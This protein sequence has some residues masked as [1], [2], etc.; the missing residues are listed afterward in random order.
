[1]GLD[2]DK[3][4][5]HTPL[6]E[7]SIEDASRYIDQQTN[8]I[9]Y[10]KTVTDEIVDVTGLSDSGFYI[11]SACINIVAPAPIISITSLTEAGQAL[12]EQTVYGGAGEYVVKKGE[13]IISKRSRWNTSELAIVLSGDI[14]VATVPEDVRELCLTIASVYTR[15]DNRIVTSEDGDME[16]I[17]ASRIPGW[18]FKSLRRL[19]RPIV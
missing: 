5:K 19:R 2:A 9:F 13:G 17:L 14:G 15:L 10:Q 16:A 8:T 4:T 3:V 18:V 6:L 11:S 12:T 1:M 7:Q